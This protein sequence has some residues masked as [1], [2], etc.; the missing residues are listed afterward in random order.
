MDEIRVDVAVL[1]LRRRLQVYQSRISKREENKKAKNKSH[2]HKQLGI[3]PEERF[4]GLCHKYLIWCYYMFGKRHNKVCEG[5]KNRSSPSRFSLLPFFYTTSYNHSP[6]HSSLHHL[7]RWLANA[8][9]KKRQGKRR[10]I[11][12]SLCQTHH[13]DPRYPFPRA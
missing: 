4:W 9:M 10:N 13:S 12:G 8:S 3:M 7:Y 11:E 1:E 5:G 6:P 2:P